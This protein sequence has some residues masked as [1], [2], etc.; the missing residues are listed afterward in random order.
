VIHVSRVIKTY[1]IFNA[2]NRP[3]WQPNC[4][5]WRPGLD[6]TDCCLIDTIG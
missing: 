5:R 6:S 4:P 1:Q 2:R 3:T